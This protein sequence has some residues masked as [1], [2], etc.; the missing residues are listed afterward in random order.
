MDI[1]IQE[2]EK[3]IELIEK[4]TLTELALTQ[5]EQSVTLK[6]TLPYAP[7]TQAPYLPTTVLLDQKNTTLTPASPAPVA[8]VEPTGHQVRSPMVGTYYSAPTPGASPFV[9]V[10][11]TVKI[12]DPL[13]IIEAMKMMNRIESDREGVVSQILLKDGSPVEFDQA[14]IVIESGHA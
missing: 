13:C 12:G 4:S 8:A 5:G 11:N 14:L 2:L 6:K 1:N 3:L 7:P 10:G 9:Q